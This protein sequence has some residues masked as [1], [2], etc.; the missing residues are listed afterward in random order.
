MVGA[1]PHLVPVLSHVVPLQMSF[2]D[3]AFIVFVIGLLLT[4]TGAFGE[5]N[6]MIV[7]LAV[8]IAALIGM[9]L[10]PYS[11]PIVLGALIPLV[12]FLL[13][14]VYRFL[15]FPRSR[16]PQQTSSASSLL[17]ASGLI[18]ETATPRGGSIELDG[19]G[20][21]PHYRCR[22]TGATIPEGERAVVVDPGGGNVLTVVPEEAFDPDQLTPV[23]AA[24]AGWKVVSDL[25]ETIAGVIERDS[26]K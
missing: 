26:R 15:E 23:D 10:G 22:T 18:L 25:R 5:P 13:Y 20:F 3:V 8:T 17:G 7:G 2:F 16:G 11:T 1:I 24:D 14:Y 6:L 9:L 12:G 19:G 4:M 21:D